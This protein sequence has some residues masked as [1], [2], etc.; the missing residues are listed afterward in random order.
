MKTTFKTKCSLYEWLI[1][2]FELT[3][4]PN[5]LM[6]LMNHILCNFIGKF[7]MDYFDDILIYNNNLEKHVKHLRNVF[8]V[9]RKIIC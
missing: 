3:N 4:T 1:M 7:V 9:L 2:L 8:D 5:T 6:R